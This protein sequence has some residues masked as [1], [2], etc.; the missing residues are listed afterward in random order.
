MIDP[1]LNLPFERIREICSR[2]HVRE[3]SIFGSALRYDFRPDSD[4]DLLVEFEPDA[5]IGLIEFGQLQQDLETLFARKVD[6]G[7]KR[8]LRPVL[9]D[10]IL[11]SAR[12]VYA[13]A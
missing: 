5:R 11:A 13:A 2:Y 7:T 12:T 3:L 10:E 8:S 1:I 9:R 4:V 6:L